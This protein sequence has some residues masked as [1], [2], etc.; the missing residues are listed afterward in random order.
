MADGTT[1]YAIMPY[2]DYQAACDAVRAADGSTEKIL[3]GSLAAKITAAAAGSGSGS[4]AGDILPYLYS[5]SVNYKN[6]TLPAELGDQLDITL[7]YRQTS[8]EGFFH[9]TKT[10]SGGLITL[11]IRTDSAIT[12]M[13]NFLNGCY[14]LDEV[15]LDF[16]TSSV[17]NYRNMCYFSSVSTT[18]Q[19]RA[20]RGV[21]DF[22]SVTSSTNIKNMFLGAEA[23]EEMTF[24]KETLKFA[25][26]I[27]DSPLLTA[28]TLASVID[29]LA[30]VETAQTLTL[31][32]T[33]AAKLTP[34][35]IAAANAKN[36]TIAY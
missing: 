14:C 2:A 15:I 34:E 23:L 7:P 11:R 13:Y 1:V 28:E 36:W 4:T 5:A 16:D 24:A 20:F 17:T 19:L 6:C 29:G 35:Q 25:L 18:S 27:E 31:H 21:I 3:S 12:T 26:E 30:P 22:S 33:A 32:A 9:S 8:L 10:A